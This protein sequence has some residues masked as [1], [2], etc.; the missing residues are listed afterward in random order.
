MIQTIG[1]AAR[2]AKGRVI[3]YADTM[4]ESMN[5]AIF[6]TQRRR[7]LQ[8]AFNEAHGITPTTVMKSVRDLLEIGRAPDE[9]DKR[10]DKQ[11]RDTLTE[12]ELHLLICSTEEKMLQAAANLDFEL[13]AKLRDKLFELQGKSPEEIAEETVAVPQRKR[14]QRRSRYVKA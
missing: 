6:E 3:M 5:K 11:R 14:R 8:Q 2:N 13:A 12:D 9:G 10:R 4:T 7:Q 1:R